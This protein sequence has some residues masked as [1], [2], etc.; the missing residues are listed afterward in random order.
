MERNIG[1]EVPEVRGKHWQE[2]AGSLPEN[3]GRKGPG[4]CRETLTGMGRE[5][6]GKHWQEGA[7]SIKG[8]TGRNGLGVWRETQA[9]RVQEFEGKHRQE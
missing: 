7:G 3:T 1:R 5:F 9:E 6:G 4:V 2:E 8:N